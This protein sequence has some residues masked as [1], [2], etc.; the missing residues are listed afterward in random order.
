MADIAR[1]TTPSPCSLECP[2]G[3]KLTLTAGE[4]IAA[5]DM[6]YVKSDGKFWKA[7]GA[8]ANA[9]AKPFGMA[10]AAAASGE[11][12]TAMHGERFNYATGLTPGASYFLSPDTAGRLADANVT[13]T[14]KH[15]IAVDA[16]RIQILPPTP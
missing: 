4:A 5:G 14:T 2:S 1:V 15:A 16:Y 13:V 11:P 10:A 3:H 6:V 12:C 8:A 7:S 9:A